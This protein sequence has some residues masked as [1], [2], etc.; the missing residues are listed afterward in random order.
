MQG[1]IDKAAPMDKRKSIS[2]RVKKWSAARPQGPRSGHPGGHSVSVSASTPSV[3]VP[4]RAPMEGVFGR[5]QARPRRSHASSRR[6][7]RFE[8][9]NESP[10]F[11]D[12][13]PRG[14][15]Q[16]LRKKN[17][18]VL[19]HRT[20]M[21]RAPLDTGRR[22]G[23]NFSASLVCLPQDPSIASRPDAGPMASAP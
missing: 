23:V 8:T 10:T 13:N 19:I 11:L 7:R 9:P 6:A 2:Y 14:S 18:Q 1:R 12:V 21:S 15:S 20:W 22:G 4:S 3:S 5:I 17:L 16:R